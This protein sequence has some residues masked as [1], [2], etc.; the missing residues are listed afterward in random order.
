MKRIF[1]AGLITLAATMESTWAQYQPQQQPLAPLLVVR[2]A[3]PPQNGA[4]L[5]NVFA[6]PTGSPGNWGRDHLGS[7]VVGPASVIGI[8]LT[9]GICVYD[10]RLVFDN[11]FSAERRSVNACASWNN[12]VEINAGIF[13]GPGVGR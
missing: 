1:I 4:I 9:P 5:Q 8:F 3:S 11:G 13:I 2:N 6:V 12:V 7:I 10:V